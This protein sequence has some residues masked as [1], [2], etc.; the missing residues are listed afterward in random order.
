MEQGRLLGID[1]GEKRI[2]LAL[3]DPLITFAYSLDT[4][5]N[6]KDFWN[7]FEDIVKQNEVRKIV[8]GMP[9]ENR[10][11]NLVSNIKSFIKKIE[12]KFHLEV[13]T[14]NEEFTS[15][16]AQQKIIQSVPKKEKRKDKGLIDKFSAAIILQE[17]IDS[18]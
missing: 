4:Y 15:V 8:I 18:L 5:L 3:S 9:N 10:N 7:K 13:I 11:R 6:D 12:N 2:G 14:W 16:I 17:Y 1:F